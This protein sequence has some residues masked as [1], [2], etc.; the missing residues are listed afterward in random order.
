MEHLIKETVLSVLNDVDDDDDK[1]SSWCFC[2][3]SMSH[4]PCTKNRRVKNQVF[5]EQYKMLPTI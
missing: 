1:M 2:F 3:L 4:V 5:V